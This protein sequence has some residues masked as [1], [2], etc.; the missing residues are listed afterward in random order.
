MVL[1]FI[2]LVRSFALLN[3]LIVV[4]ADSVV[5]YNPALSLSHITYGFIKE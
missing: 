2:S 1:V 3:N 5:L 4:N